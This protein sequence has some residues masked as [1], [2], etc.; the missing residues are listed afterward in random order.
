[1]V[2]RY[3]GALEEPTAIE[4]AG[5]LPPGRSADARRDAMVPVRPE[6]Y[7]P[8][9][10]EKRMTPAEQRTIMNERFRFLRG[11]I[12]LSTP[13]A[14]PKII[15]IT[16]PDK[17]CGKTFVSR[18]VS[19]AL[20]KLDKKVLLVDSDLRNPSLHRVFRY[21]NRIGLTS[22]L[23]GQKDLNEGCVMRTDVDNLF[24]LMSGPKSPSP[25]ELLASRVMDET[26]SRCSE[27]FDYVV[28]DSAPLLP[29]FDS[30]TL[31]PRCDAVVLVTRSGSTSWH[32]ALSSIEL[33]E[34]VNGKITGVVLNDVNLQ[35]RAQ[36]YYYSYYS[37][38][39]GQYGG[40]E[41]SA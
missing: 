36:N 39:Y 18:H 34:R 37:Y 31:A 20:A 14:G 41:R 8:A 4:A 23:T 30:H 7:L 29:V 26:L 15:L 1:M 2:P 13:G 16:S 28:L 12:L 27:H 35:D 38:E 11:S 21:R 32:A 24:L 19:R 5:Q 10:S 22:V 9:L 3:M 6:K 17:N 25:G 33:V 40:A